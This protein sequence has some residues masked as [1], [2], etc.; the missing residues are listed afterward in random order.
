MKSNY[1]EIGV[2]ACRLRSKPGGR[3]LAVTNRAHLM[4]IVTY[5]RLFVGIDCKS[6]VN[7]LHTVRAQ[8]YTFWGVPI[9]TLPF[10]LK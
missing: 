1:N 2:S 10:E 9:A 7:W 5:S 8:L 3:I 4:N 6:L